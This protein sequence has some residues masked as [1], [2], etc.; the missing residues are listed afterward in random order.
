MLEDCQSHKLE[1]II[2]KSINRFGRDTVETLEALQLIKD[3]G[4]RVIFEQGN[5]DTADTNSELMISLVE[6]FAQ[7][8]NESRSD[9]IKW[10][11]KQK[12]SSGTSKL[13]SEVLW[14]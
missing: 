9:N 5:L 11:L 8:E 2:T 10:G 4:V 3:S 7:A 13:F 6:S 12:A 1:M 14:L